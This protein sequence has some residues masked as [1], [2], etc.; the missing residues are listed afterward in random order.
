MLNSD[1]QNIDQLFDDAG[2]DDVNFDSDTLAAME[3]EAVSFIEQQYQDEESQKPD[4][5]YQTGDD[6]TCS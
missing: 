5:N 3:D 4:Q 6:G 1:F 2:Q